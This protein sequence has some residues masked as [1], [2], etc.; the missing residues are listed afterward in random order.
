MATKEL[1]N[2]VSCGALVPDGDDYPWPG[3]KDDCALVLEWRQDHEGRKRPVV[4]MY[5]ILDQVILRP[6]MFFGRKEITS[7]FHF[8][9]GMTILTDDRFGQV[10]YKPKNDLF[11]E[12][13]FVDWIR[14]KKGWA[15][16]VF[17]AHHYVSEAKRQLRVQGIDEPSTIQVEALGFD[18]FVED[19]K[20]FRAQAG[21]AL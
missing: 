1:D 15:R 7:F 12:G 11:A 3:H 8:Y 9:L 19:L 16:N 2:C 6:A 14:D 18:I 17:T 10:V 20:E 4:D 21:E 13:G 5:G